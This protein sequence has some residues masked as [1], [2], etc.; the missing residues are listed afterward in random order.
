MDYNYEMMQHKKGD[1]T[2]ISG[3]DFPICGCESKECLIL[4]LLQKACYR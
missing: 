3:N 2:C 4:Y 1:T